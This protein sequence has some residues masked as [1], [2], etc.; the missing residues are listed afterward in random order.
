[1]KERSR[2]RNDR[3]FA[4]SY[5]RFKTNKEKETQEKSKK[6]IEKQKESDSH[7][8]TDEETGEGSGQSSHGNQD[9]DVS[10]H[11]EEDEEC[12][13]CEKE[14]E[15]IEL[16]KRSSKESEEHLKKTNIPCWIEAHR[17]MKWRMAMR[18]ASLPQERWTNRRTEWNL[19][20][21][22]KIKTN[23]SVGRPRKRWE[24]EIN[25]QLRKEEKAEAKKLEE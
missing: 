13:K 11:E 20:L 15:W 16:I 2:P 12:G 3:C 7:C 14:E 4:S 25:E 19:G 22:N 17:R 21:H 18:I 1:M 8:A 9:S 23:R 24:D 10:F 5:R 6:G